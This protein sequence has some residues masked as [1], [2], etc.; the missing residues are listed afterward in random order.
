[1]A[2]IIHKLISKTT[3]TIPSLRIITSTLKTPQLSDPNYLTA[4]TTSLLPGTTKSDFS[5]KPIPL[6]NAIPT[7]DVKPLQFYYPNFPF[8]FCLNPISATG[9]G[10]VKAME[11]DV[12]DSRTLWADSVK[13]KRKKKMNKHKYQKLRKRLGRKIGVLDFVVTFEIKVKK[14][15]KTKRILFEVMLPDR[16]LKTVFAFI[17]TPK[18]LSDQ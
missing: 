6:L 1:M 8:G 16:V 7:Q 12:D 15:I 13:K 2:N 17:K 18:L 3:P 5:N 14:S 11:D 10:Q 4:T 9:F